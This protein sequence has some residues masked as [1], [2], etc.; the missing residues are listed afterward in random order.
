M[1]CWA[2]TL[3]LQGACQPATEDSA[4]DGTGDV[5]EPAVE[6]L[7]WQLDDE[8][9]SL[10]YVTWEQ[11]LTGDCYVEYLFE[12][13]QWRQ[14]PVRSAE[15]GPQSQLLLG[16]PYGQELRF[17]VVIELADGTFTSEEGLAQTDD[18]P[19][20]L[21][22]VRSVAFGSSLPDPD[23]PYVLLSL[24][25][26]SLGPWWTVI[27][28]RQGRYVWAQQDPY[29][30]VTMKARP[31][32]DG[33][34]L[35]IDHNTYWSLYD[36]GESSQV[37]RV[38]ID[39]SFM[40]TYPTPGLHHSLTEVADNGL[41]WGAYPPDETLQAQD[42]DG[43]QRTIWSCEEFHAELGIEQECASNHVSWDEASDSLLYSF[44]TSETVIRIDRSSG[45]TTGWFGQLPGAW[46]FDP[47]ESVFWWQHGANLTDEGTLL[48]STHTTREDEEIMVREYAL[49][50]EAQTLREIWSFGEG[51]GFRSLSGGSA[52]RL[53]GGNTLHNLGS[54]PRLREI[55]P[56]G[57]VVWDVAWSMER[58]IG[59]STA[60]GDLYDFEL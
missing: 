10:V 41:L 42:A 58:K 39:G 49:D 38:K 23:Y 37:V 59:D 1:G 4:S 52:Q 50:E 32:L 21:P 48:I 44:I 11:V 24:D 30:S 27:I 9:G 54:N 34:G 60:L 40:A 36:E 14:S 43:E 13:D 31:A 18:A 46:T 35:L 22:E 55:S 5:R 2:L 7:D 12:G 57:E 47:P 15:S 56:E 53:S 16:V 8:I 28:D 6:A 51:E 19:S 29:G 25:T 3:A 33:K 45:E 17:R 26:E 20:D